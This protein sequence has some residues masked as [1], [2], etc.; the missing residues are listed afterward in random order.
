MPRFIGQFPLQDGGSFGTV[1]DVRFIVAF[2]FLLGGISAAVAQEQEGKLLDRLPRPNMELSN[3]ASKK[4]FLADGASINKR[5]PTASFYTP[6]KSLTKP[7]PSKRTFFSKLFATRHSQAGDATANLSTRSRLTNTNTA[8][9]MP[10]GYPTRDASGSNGSVRGSDF[11]GNRPFL[12][13]GKSQKALSTQNKPLTID[14][15]RE[16]LNKNK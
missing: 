7:F 12:D 5:A 9:I 15:V 3:P 2:T 11:R 13:R 14:Q 6:E 4:H 10:A 8:Y 1:G 16:L